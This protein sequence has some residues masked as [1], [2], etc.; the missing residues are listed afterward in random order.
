MSH[1]PSHALVLMQT[2]ARLTVSLDGM[3]SSSLRLR[4][5]PSLSD[6]TSSRFLTGLQHEWEIYKPSLL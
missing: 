4:G 1:F 3:A 5:T 2:H 6:R